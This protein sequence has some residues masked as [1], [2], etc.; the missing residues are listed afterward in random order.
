MKTGLILALRG[1]AI[2]AMAT[3][4][5]AGLTGAPLEALALRSVAPQIFRPM[6]HEFGPT[7][8]VTKTLEP[9]TYDT[10]TK[11]M[12]SGCVTRSPPD[13]ILSC[14][15]GSRAGLK[16]HAASYTEHQSVSVGV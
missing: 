14:S 9:S 5:G 7:H 15:R 1:L 12:R 4:R 11:S 10:P 8:R 16:K 3:S 6:R 2:L 13:F